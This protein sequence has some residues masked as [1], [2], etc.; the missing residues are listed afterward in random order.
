LLLVDW[1]TV[2]LAVPERDLWS[3]ATGPD[4]LA[5]YADASGHRPDP[6]ALALYRLRWDLEEVAIYL[7]EFRS[8]HERTPDTELSWTGLTDSVQQLTANGH[9]EPAP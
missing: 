2:G 1:D 3:V 8:P 5:R 7:G 9:A 4:D 6:E